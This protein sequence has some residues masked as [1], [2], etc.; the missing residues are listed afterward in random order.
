MSQDEQP[1]PLEAGTQGEGALEH[2]WVVERMDQQHSLRAD[3][4][5]FPPQV[6][7]RQVWRDFGSLHLRRTKVQ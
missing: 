1:R 6:L 7:L 3:G 4:S 5:S 2:A